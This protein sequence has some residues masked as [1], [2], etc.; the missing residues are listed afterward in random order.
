MFTHGYSFNSDIRL[1]SAECTIR[2]LNQSDRNNYLYNP[3][4]LEY[5]I[6]VIILSL[7]DQKQP[8]PHY[9]P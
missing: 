1:H 9:V 2:L 4:L 6:Y 7:E 5:S 3:K 8:V